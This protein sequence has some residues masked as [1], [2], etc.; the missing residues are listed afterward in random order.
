L[1][2]VA[3]YCLFYLGYDAFGEV[4]RQT[5]AM[6]MSKQ[7]QRNMTILAPHTSIQEKGEIVLSSLMKNSEDLAQINMRLNLLAE[8]NRIVAKKQE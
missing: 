6:R 7:F 3:V 4:S 8:K 1:G 2:T 5:A